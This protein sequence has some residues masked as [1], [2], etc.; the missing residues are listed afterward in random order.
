MMQRVKISQSENLYYPR[1]SGNCPT[2]VSICFFIASYHSLKYYSTS[3]SLSMTSCS[4]LLYASR[5]YSIE[6]FVLAKASTPIKIIKTNHDISQKLSMMSRT[7][8]PNFS[9]VRKNMTKRIHRN[10]A[11]QHQN[12]QKT[13]S[14]SR[15]PLSHKT[16]MRMNKGE[17]GLISLVLPDLK[18]LPE[19]KKN[20]L[21]SKIN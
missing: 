11:A 19:V 10:R 16:M 3:Q 7:Y 12:V 13:S 9:Y 18:Q 14:L 4:F 6:T 2:T 21:N 8:G 5:A 17:R 20:A 15:L 1:S